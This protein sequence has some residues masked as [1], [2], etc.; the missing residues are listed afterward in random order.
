MPVMGGIEC[1]KNIRTTVRSD[2]Q[3]TI[4]ALTG[5]I[6]EENRQNCLDAGMDAVLAK[7]INREKLM[8][9]LNLRTNRAQN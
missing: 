4:I 6:L 3:P 2:F 8:D 7:P 5:D 1:T 9:A